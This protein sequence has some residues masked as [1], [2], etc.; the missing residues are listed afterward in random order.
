MI[1]VDAIY[2]DDNKQDSGIRIYKKLTEAIKISNSSDVI[3]IKPATYEK[4][5]IRSS[6]RLFELTINGSGFNTI[7]P[8]CNFEGFLDLRFENIKMET[9]NIISSSSVFVFKNVKFKSL[10]RITLKNYSVFLGVDPR[11]CILFDNCTFD[12]NYQIILENSNYMLSFKSCEIKGT[13]PLVYLKKGELS[14]KITNINLEYPILHNSNG[15]CEIQHVGC[16]F[17]CN[18]YEGSETLIYSKDN[19]FFNTPLSI[20]EN[21]AS[22]A[23]IVGTENLL[24]KLDNKKA[25][26]VNS[27]ENDSLE[28]NEHH[29]IILNEG[30]KILS[31]ILPENSKNGH[32][33]T[34]FTNSNLKFNNRVFRCKKLQLIFI[35]DYGW[36]AIINESIHK[37][38]TEK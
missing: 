6:E 11:T 22:T 18:L 17:I 35:N 7:L 16:N 28:I 36:I 9:C 27:N 14:L 34:I 13:I 25:I 20:N 23:V 32:S 8:H 12:Y 24:N 26:V 4:I 37:L 3:N 38:S 5:N 2:G 29:R 21:S 1:E 31:C 30:L 10:N 19:V 33:V 15:V